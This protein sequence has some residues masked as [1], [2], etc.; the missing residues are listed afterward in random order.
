MDNSSKD[1]EWLIRKAYTIWDGLKIAQL[2]D[3]G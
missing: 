1:N 3:D 2:I